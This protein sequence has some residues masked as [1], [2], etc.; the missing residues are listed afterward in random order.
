[1][2]IREGIVYHHGDIIFLPKADILGQVIAKWDKAV[3]ALAFQLH[4]VQVDLGGLSGG[5][6]FQENLFTLVRCR[7]GKRLFIPCG[8]GIYA[9]LAVHAGFSEVIKRIYVIIGMGQA[10]RFPACARDIARFIRL[11]VHR[12]HDNLTLDV[13]VGFRVVPAVA[14]GE[15]PA[16]V[17][18]EFLAGRAF[19]Y[20][21]G[22]SD[23]KGL[24]RIRIAGL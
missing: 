14:L 5:F 21:P 18:I 6:K 11:F 10:D 22:Y 17:K 9:A 12:E 1:M 8:P 3:F 13:A 16:R 4:T 15:D 19:H 7:N 2:V 24:R 20:R 23:R